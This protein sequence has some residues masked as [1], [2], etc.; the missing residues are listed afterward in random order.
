MHCE[1]SDGGGSV[2]EAHQSVPPHINTA[3]SNVLDALYLLILFTY[4]SPIS[5]FPQSLCLEEVA[6]LN[7]SATWLRMYKTSPDVIR[8][9]ATR[10]C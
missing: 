9:H 8:I 4:L 1:L 7:R 2:Q 6:L 3:E 10:I 5:P